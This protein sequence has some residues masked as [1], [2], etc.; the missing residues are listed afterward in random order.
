MRRLGSEPLTPAKKQRR[1]R[2]KTKAL[3]AQAKR[4]ARAFDDEESAQLVALYRRSAAR[5][6][7][8]EAEI[9]QLLAAAAALAADFETWARARIELELSALRARQSARASSLVA[10][11]EPLREKPEGF[12]QAGPAS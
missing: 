12:S 1:Y 6:G 7:A 2:E 5:C 8:S 9:E 11:L 3:L 10:R 4:F